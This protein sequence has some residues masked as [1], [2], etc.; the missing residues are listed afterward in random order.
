VGPEES[1][2]LFSPDLGPTSTPEGP[3]ICIAKHL[4]TFHLCSLAK[5]LMQPKGRNSKR[6]F[7]HSL[8]NINIMETG[9]EQNGRSLA[10]VV[11]GGLW[12]MAMNIL[13]RVLCRCGNYKKL[14]RSKQLNQGTL[15]TWHSFTTFFRVLEFS[16]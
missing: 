10:K 2:H 7:P 13:A 3:R 12:V 15:H 9:R 11:S 4:Q 16:S 5:Y 14:K 6:I 8:C 1:C